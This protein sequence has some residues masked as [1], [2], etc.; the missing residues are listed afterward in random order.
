[1]NK[2]KKV[3]GFI[4]LGVLL[5]ASYFLGKKWNETKPKEGC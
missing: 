5:G 3:K 1:M 2:V 4:L